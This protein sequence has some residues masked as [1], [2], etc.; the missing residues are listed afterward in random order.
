MARLA[1]PAIVPQS[2]QNTL[3]NSYMGRDSMPPITLL[4][5]GSQFFP[6]TSQT[7]RGSY[8]FSLHN[9][10]QP[11]HPAV[12]PSGHASSSLIGPTT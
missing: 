5:V 10:L 7:T 2:V 8:V 4:D 1:T 9:I 3:S 6:S 12:G 11:P